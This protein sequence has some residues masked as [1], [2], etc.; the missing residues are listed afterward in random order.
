MRMAHS[1][2]TSGALVH[3]PG[4]SQRDLS[5]FASSNP[6][7][8]WLYTHSIFPPATVD[9]AENTSEVGLL[10]GWNGPDT[11]FQ[12]DSWHLL[13]NNQAKQDLWM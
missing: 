7:F 6:H 5:H 1:S 8:F 13:V 3:F 11:H 4:T 9:R 12:S 2:S 10:F